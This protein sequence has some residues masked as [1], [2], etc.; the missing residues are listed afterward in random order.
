MQVGDQGEALELD[1]LETSCNTW[2]LL[3]VYGAFLLLLEMSR[4]AGLQQN[5]GVLLL[6]ACYPL[7]V[8]FR[9]SRADQWRWRGKYAPGCSDCYGAFAVSRDNHV[10]CRWGQASHDGGGFNVKLSHATARAILLCPPPDIPQSP[11]QL[12]V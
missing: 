10:L 7:S 4:E 1:F 12:S 8:R 5:I 3:A 11:Q 9:W 6:L 2:R